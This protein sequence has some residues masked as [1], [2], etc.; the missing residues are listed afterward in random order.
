MKS[1]NEIIQLGIEFAKTL[2]A[3]NESYLAGAAFGYSCGYEAAQPTPSV[4]ADIRDEVINLL[5]MCEHTA[6]RN[7]GEGCNHATYI[8]PSEYNLISD[9]IYALFASRKPAGMRWVKASERLPILPDPLPKDTIDE[10]GVLFVNR[11]HSAGAFW[12][13]SYGVSALSFLENYNGWDVTEWEWLDE[14]TPSNWIE[15]KEGE[16]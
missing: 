16:K 2:K 6:H 10:R 9:K 1:Q 12:Y 4:S 13:P 8:L 5:K 7:V 3:D 11:A 14:S 15:I